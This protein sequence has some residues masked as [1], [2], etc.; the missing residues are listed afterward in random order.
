MFNITTYLSDDL[1]IVDYSD[2][3]EIK[4]CNDMEKGLETILRF[5]PKNLN[6]EESGIVLK[7]SSEY[8]TGLKKIMK[9]DTPTIKTQKSSQAKNTFRLAAH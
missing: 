9:G 1:T 2:R 8:V 5:L 6:F 3:L 7:G 4:K